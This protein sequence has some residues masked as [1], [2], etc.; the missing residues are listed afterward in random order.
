[1]GIYDRDYYRED[2]RWSNPFARSQATLFLT[3]LLCFMFIVQVAGVDT[4][5]RVRG[6]LPQPQRDSVAEAL[7]LN[8]PKV[9]DGEVWRVA[10]YALVHQ[11][12]SRGVIHIIFT[13]VFL[14]WIGR[15]VEDLYGSWE[16]LAY[17]G[18]TS[19]IGGVAY[20]VVGAFT[21]NGLALLG[22]SGA[23]TAVLVLF[24]LHYPARTLP[25]WFIPV[26]VWLLVAVYALVDIAGL[27]NGHANPA[28][29]AVHLA[30]AAFAFAYHTYTLRV[31]NW[32]PGGRG[33]ASP[34]RRAPRP[35]P[36]PRRDEPQP[37]PAA[38]AST[39]GAA[40][41]VGVGGGSSVDE[42]L[43]AKLDEVLE[44]VQ[45]HGKE[46]LTEDEREILLKASEIYKKR[47]RPG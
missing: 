7:E 15:Q 32:L 6:P 23:V 5:P 8:V 31:L 47:R 46:S 37:E 35:K 28:A 24:A 30:G 10:T 42:H 3:L 9:L 43:E 29:V 19:L 13:A 33:T 44:K 22:P 34:A 4:R 12:G 16:Y 1:M 20:T 39:A 45:R 17:F 14:V 25:L 41:A 27:A 38:A 18:L 26:P 40:G 11:P 36:R 2:S 21:N